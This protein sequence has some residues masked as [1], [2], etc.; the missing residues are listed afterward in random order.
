MTHAVVVPTFEETEQY[1]TQRTMFDTFVQSL[2][3]ACDMACL[4]DDAI[5]R[6]IAEVRREHDAKL[7]L[8][9]QKY[10]R[11]ELNA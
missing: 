9:R 8:L 4:S 1:R 5:Q 7:H 6:A 10:E 11:G 3:A 2:V